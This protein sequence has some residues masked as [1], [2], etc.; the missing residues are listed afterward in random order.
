MGT[1]LKIIAPLPARGMHKELE[2]DPDLAVSAGFEVKSPSAKRRIV[3]ARHG[4]FPPTVYIGA[5]V[6]NRGGDLSKRG[7]EKSVNTAS[8]VAS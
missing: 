6:D 8:S 2:R 1:E 4:A 7:L 5:K 3:D